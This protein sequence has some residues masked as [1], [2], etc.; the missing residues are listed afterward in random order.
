MLACSLSKMPRNYQ[1]KRSKE[2]PSEEALHK[3]VAVVL[4]GKLSIRKAAD[5]YELSPSTVGFYSK[6]RVAIFTT[7]QCSSCVIKKMECN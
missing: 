3:A 4:G 7:V 1:R 2:P 6:G 5:K